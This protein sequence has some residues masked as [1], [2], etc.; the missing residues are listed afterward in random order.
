MQLTPQDKK[1]WN[2]VRHI[3]NYL[4]KRVDQLSGVP[5]AF[6]TQT[7]YQSKDRY[8][9]NYRDYFQRGYAEPASVALVNEMKGV[10]R[11]E[12]KAPDASD[13]AVNDRVTAGALAVHAW[14]EHLMI[15]LATLGVTYAGSLQQQ[16][17]AEQTGNAVGNIMVANYLKRIGVAR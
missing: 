5:N 3:Q 16:M 9:N 15:K 11:E 2:V 12:G 4:Y 17:R 10:V 6:H 7:T 13:H 14:S 8:M 1:L